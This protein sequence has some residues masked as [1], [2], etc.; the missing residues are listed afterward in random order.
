MKRKVEHL[1][2]IMDIGYNLGMGITMRADEFDENFFK[3]LREIPAM[4]SEKEVKP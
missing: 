2:A 4:V 3:K 1:K